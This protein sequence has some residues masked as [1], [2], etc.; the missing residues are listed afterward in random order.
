MRTFWDVA[1]T[2]FRVFLSGDGALYVRFFRF[3]LDD[4]D[5][6]VVVQSWAPFE[7]HHQFGWMYCDLVPSVCFVSYLANKTTQNDANGVFFSM[8]AR[9]SESCFAFTFQHTRSFRRCRRFENDGIH[10]HPLSIPTRHKNDSANPLTPP[11]LALLKDCLSQSLLYLCSKTHCG[12]AVKRAVSQRGGVLCDGV[13]S[14]EYGVVRTVSIQYE[15]TVGEGK[16]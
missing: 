16:P 3:S 10:I 6:E 14:L 11:K 1:E 12:D 15:H 8:V 5:G 2:R 7:W 13:L 4:T 9:S